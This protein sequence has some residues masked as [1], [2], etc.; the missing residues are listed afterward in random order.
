MSDEEEA[1]GG[2]AKPRTRP[3]PICG[4]MALAAY[5]PFCSDRCRARDLNQWLSGGYAI[6]AE[7][8][9]E[10]PNGSPL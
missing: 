9:D 7:E 3:C 6:P 4:R 2:Q 8:D 5:H 10:D 1:P